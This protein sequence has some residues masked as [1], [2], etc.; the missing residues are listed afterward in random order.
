MKI[1][2]SFKYAIQGISALFRSERNAQ[3]ELVAACVAIAAAFYFDVSKSDWI[4]VLFCI[5]M[6]F[7]AE[8]F[9][10]A[11]ETLADQLHPEKHEQIGRAKDI[12]AG[13]VLMVAAVAAIAG[14]L[15]FLPYF[16]ST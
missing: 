2:L 11:L 1:L 16:S 10:T 3:I 14:I 6:V 7:S 5:G 15:I 12:A 13:A 4:A 8:A 9:N